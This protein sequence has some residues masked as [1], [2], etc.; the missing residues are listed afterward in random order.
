VIP[1][2]NISLFCKGEECSY[3]LDIDDFL[4][5]SPDELTLSKGDLIELIERDDNFRDGWYLGRS[6]KNG[7]SGLSPEG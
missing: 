6:L 1:K 7:I 5:R 2:L 3:L 4:A